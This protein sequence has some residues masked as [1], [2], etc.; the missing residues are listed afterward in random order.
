MRWDMSH[1]GES[2]PLVYCA[3]PTYGRP[4]LLNE[5][6]EAFLRQDYPGPKRLVICNDDSRVKYEIDYPD[7]AVLNLPKRFDFLG[8]KLNFMVDIMF[9]AEPE[10]IWLGWADD[11]IMLPHAISAAMAG[12]V[13]KQVWYPC[14]RFTLHGARIDRYKDSIN[15]APAF[16][17]VFYNRLKA[18]TLKSHDRLPFA[19]DVASGED[20]SF[21]YPACELAKQE[22]LSGIK[23]VFSPEDVYYLYR[24][25]TGS[26]HLSS[27]RDMENIRQEVERKIKPGRY[28]INPGWNN[29]YT[30]MAA[31]FARRV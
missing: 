7:I 23:T 2:L 19:E 17:R 27:R 5:A 12:M 4:G 11:D 28:K 1:W 21:Y 9:I 18:F 13:N 8:Q 15:F 6:V 14:G 3:C 24:W 25:G 31:D 16:S 20:K 10:S 26:Y 30:A 29:N 22:K